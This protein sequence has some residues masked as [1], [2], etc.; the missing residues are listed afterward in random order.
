LLG[1]LEADRAAGVDDDVAGGALLV[2][3]TEAV[4]DEPTVTWGRIL[5]IVLFETPAFAKS[6]TDE[7]GRPAIIFFAVAGPTP[8]RS[9][10]S[11]P[12]ALFKSTVPPALVLSFVALAVFGGSDFAG[13]RRLSRPDRHL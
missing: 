1:A 8:G 12:V 11:F 5:A 4:E 10:S 7:Y 9:S 2:L 13:C 3:G 6:S